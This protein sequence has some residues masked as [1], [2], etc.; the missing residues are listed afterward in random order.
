MRTILRK[1]IENYISFEYLNDTFD[2]NF[3]QES[4]IEKFEIEFKKFISFYNSVFYN[5]NRFVTIFNSNEIRIKYNDLKLILILYIYCENN[6]LKIQKNIIQDFLYTYHITINTHEYE[7]NYD[8]HK[9]SKME[10]KQIIDELNI[11]KKFYVN[12]QNEI[13]DF[14]K[15]II[16]YGLNEDVFIDGETITR[17]FNNL[18]YMR[19]EYSE[20]IEIFITKKKNIYN[21]IKYDDSKSKHI[22]VYLE[23]IQDSLENIGGYNYAKE[24]IF[25]LDKDCCL[26]EKMMNK[27]I[28]KYI[29][30]TND[31][32]NKLKTKEE[33][34]IRGISEIE[35]LRKEYIFLLENV[36]NFT[37]KHK[38]KI[39]ECL[40]RLL[41]LKRFIISDEEYVKA[42][43]HESVF[44]HKVDRGKI[45][46]YRK[47]L[48]ENTLRLYN[49]SKIKFT[50]E[51]ANALE[52]YS[53]YPLHSLVSRYT[54]DSKREVYGLCIEE[55]KKGDNNKFKKYFDILGSKYTKTHTSLTN[56]I[57]SNYYEELLKYMSTTF[58]LHQRLLVSTLTKED[59]NTLINS[60]KKSINY[61]FENQYAIIIS[62]I[63]A[64]E[65]NVVKILEQYNIEISN[66]GFTNLNSLFEICKDDDEKVN[67]LMYINYIL[68]EKSGMNLRNNATH[69]TLINEDLTIPLIVSFSGL[70]FISWLLKWN[71]D[72]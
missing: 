4:S 55:Q 65:I 42:Q 56:I 69:G 30:I 41:K 14:Y 50:E 21:I 40:T 24:V 27:I 10:L 29:K 19:K 47:S 38:N 3:S 70:I 18:K 35:V 32:I 66:D 9:E 48:M 16:C 53:K 51:M 49:A 22:D 13:Y 28:N 2:Y 57:S 12:F 52:M 44:E 67:G 37:E 25:E 39:K 34:F 5:G 54:I 45:E 1:Y 71:K 62:N 63:L 68:Y 26:N 17:I 58:E 8:K 33:T 60:L 72:V 36:D 11:R 46:E 6:N 59:F 31:L 7:N 23:Y 61:N 20:L 15:E 43:M 64:I